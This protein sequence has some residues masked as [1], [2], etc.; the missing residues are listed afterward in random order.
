MTTRSCFAK[1]AIA[2]LP[3]GCSQILDLGKDPTLDDSN[4]AIDAPI[5]STDSMAPPTCMPSAC[6]FGCDTTTS[7]CREGKLLIYKTSAGFFGNDFGGKDI[8]PDVRV[9]ADG[10]CLVAYSQ[11]YSTRGCQ[12]NNVHAV[13]QISG[14]DTLSLMPVKYNIPTNIPVYRIDDGVLVSNNWND[15]TDP[16]RS[17]RASATNATSDAE[18]IVWTGANSNATCQNWTSAS[19]TSSGTRGYTNRTDSSWLNED[20]FR[21]DRSASLLC[22]CWP[23]GV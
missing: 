10:I 6:Q 5:G 14:S 9:S 12:A 22:I 17:L 13:L 15:L 2:A 23:S 21:C 20:T 18:G 7:M 8:P 4:I 1:I 16:L 19:S 3:A 11:A